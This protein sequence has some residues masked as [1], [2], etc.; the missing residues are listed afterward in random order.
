LGEEQQ[1]EPVEILVIWLILSVIPGVI[2]SDKGRSGFGYFLLSVV[3]SPLIGLIAALV[4]S[5]NTERTEQ[6]AVA[7]GDARKCPF[8][9]EL[10]KPEAVVCKHCGR[11][12]PAPVEP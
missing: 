9:A 11:D 6:R 2:A 7:Q 5:S 8:C 3:L 4:V 12:L 1:G 10:I